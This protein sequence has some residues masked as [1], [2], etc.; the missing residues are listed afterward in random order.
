MLGNLVSK[1]KALR[2]TTSDLGGRG[3]NSETGQERDRDRDRERERDGKSKMAMHMSKLNANMRK[4]KLLVMARRSGKEPLP[5]GPPPP[6]SN[7]ANSA[8]TTTTT[9]TAPSNPPK[10]KMPPRRSQPLPKLPF[11]QDS[12]SEAAYNRATTLPHP[13]LL[14][15][16]RRASLYSNDGDHVNASIESHALEFSSDI[17]DI[18]FN[19]AHSL[20]NNIHSNSLSNHTYSNHHHAA[21][22]PVAPK[23]AR[24]PSSCSS[25]LS[26]FSNSINILDVSPSI[27]SIPRNSPPPPS[28]SIRA[29]TLN[30]SFYSPSSMASLKKAARLDSLMNEIESFNEDANDSFESSRHSSMSMSRVH[31]IIPITTTTAT[32]GHKKE[33][34]KNPRERAYETAFGATASLTSIRRA[35]LATSNTSPEPHLT[36]TSETPTTT[37]TTIEPLRVQPHRRTP[38]PPPAH[39]PTNKDLAYIS[40]ILEMQR[41]QQHRS[42]TSTSSYRHNRNLLK[43]GTS[44]G[45]RSPPLDPQEPHNASLYSPVAASGSFADRS[46]SRGSNRSSRSYLESPQPSRRHAYKSVS[47]VDRGWNRDALPRG[48]DDGGPV[49]LLEEQLMRLERVYEEKGWMYAAR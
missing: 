31:N 38:Q 26:D 22:T 29:A 32:K 43:Y 23:K 33:H 36:P 12:D 4:V 24:N 25:G 10:A 37:T 9:F 41:L 28:L 21:A 46:S 2:R 15:A 30:P 8:A 20:P 14:S 39:V 42:N 13:R 49:V 18:A 1:A 11:E 45:T 3:S 19:Q 27:L 40:E 6:P 47:P 16:L 35:S 48:V 5:K 17:S 7:V 44:S 34:R